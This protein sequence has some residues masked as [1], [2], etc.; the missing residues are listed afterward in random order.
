MTGKK[1]I[2]NLLLLLSITGLNGHFSGIRAVVSK[3]EWEK[4]SSVE[5]QRHDPRLKRDLSFK[6]SLI[7][8]INKKFSS[9]ENENI[10]L[11][12]QSVLCKLLGGRFDASSIPLDDKA[13]Y[14]KEFFATLIYR[15]L[16]NKI[17]NN[18]PINPQ[19]SSWIS[20]FL[21]QKVKSVDDF[22]KFDDMDKLNITRIC[23]MCSEHHALDGPTL[24]RVLEII[25][26]FIE[27]NYVSPKLLVTYAKIPYKTDEQIAALTKAIKVLP[28][29][30]PRRVDAL[31]ALAR[32]PHNTDEQI[33][34]LKEAIGILDALGRPSKDPQ[35]IE[36]L[37]AL[38]RIPH[39]TDKQVN[40]LEELNELQI[41]RLTG[42]IEKTAQ[43]IL[44]HCR[45]CLS[46]ENRCTLEM[47]IS[48]PRQRR[49]HPV[50][51]VFRKSQKSVRYA[52]LS[53]K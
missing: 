11:Y 9:K 5:D 22:K 14:E 19:E 13:L 51:G 48:G 8:D 43:N 47:I 15:I 32:I 44:F 6:E 2:A 38:A 27:T 16:G 52:D 12:Y 37:L 18:E 10:E 20:D 35:R 39:D 1:I 26:R 34:A 17:N 25:G 41:P 3:D 30:D 50:G 36:A 45:G 4:I 31:I 28:K 24:N 29:N 49:M 7:S 33:N 21:T 46:D 23:L 40:A 53:R 42:Q